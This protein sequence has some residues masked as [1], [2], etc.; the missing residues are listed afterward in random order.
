MLVAQGKWKYEVAKDM[1]AFFLTQLLE[2]CKM[3]LFRFKRFPNHAN[4]QEGN[5]TLLV[6]VDASSSLVIHSF[7]VHTSEEG[8]M[9]SPS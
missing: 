1:W 3:S 7:L 6:L 9:W 5:A 8:E 4:C 2:L